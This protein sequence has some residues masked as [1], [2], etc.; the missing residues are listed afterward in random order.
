MRVRPHG[1]AEEC[2][3]MAGLLA[4]LEPAI[5]IVS[6]SQPYQDRGRSRLCRVYLELVYLELR[7]PP[8]ADDFPHVPRQGGLSPMPIKA[9]TTPAVACALLQPARFSPRILR[10]CGRWAAQVD[11]TAA[12]AE[13]VALSER[14]GRWRGVGSAGRGVSPSP[15]RFE[16]EV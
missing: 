7:L 11:P 2:E 10:A 13:F 1:T 5:S 15:A 9:I 14:E 12:I 3:Q 8:A 16:E 4:R 6:V